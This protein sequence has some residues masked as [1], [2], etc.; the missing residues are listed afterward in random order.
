LSVTDSSFDRHVSGI[1]SPN[2]AKPARAIA[3]KVR[4]AALYPA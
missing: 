4:N 1:A 3:A 2:K